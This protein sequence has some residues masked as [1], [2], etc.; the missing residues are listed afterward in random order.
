MNEQSLPAAL[1][2]KMPPEWF[3]HHSTWL[4]W[5]KN[6]TTWPDRVIQVQKIYLQ[7]ISLLSSHEKIDLL[8]DKKSTQVSILK[9]LK[10]YKVP[11]QQIRFHLI[12][13]ADSWI[14]DYGPNFIVRLR[15]GN[16]E[17]AFNHWKFN[18]WGNKYEDLKQDTNIPETL[19]SVFK[20]PRFT[21]PLVLEGGAFD[22]NGKGIC[23]TTE[24]CL[25]NP[26]RNPNYSRSEI[27]QYLANF[28]GINKVIWLGKGI[29]GSDTDGHVDELARFI[30]SNT[31][32]CA[33]E[34]DPSDENYSL[35]Q[36]N[37]QRLEKAR[38]LKGHPFKIV[39]LPMPKAV[40]I[41]QKRL[42]AS[43]ANFYIANK[44][45]LVP[46]FNQTRDQNAI[47]ILQKNF[48]DRK[49]IGVD[50][51]DMLLGMGTLHCITQQQ[52]ESAFNDV[53]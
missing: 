12:P 5:P 4:A 10:E 44:M 48:H 45:V 14:R 21:P 32:I 38:D 35:L 50:C 2:Y 36:E 24:S 16:K 19:E 1:G 20:V 39:S 17:L 41:S 30:N 9:Q 51:S 49:V 15:K 29:V 22:I 42:P 3:P 33:I 23:L 46:T 37:Y 34:E 40:Q 6:S 26:N 27:E 43:Y 25:L 31:I 13:T 28:I 18:S 52:P 11:L 53:G 47:K 7:L 8:V